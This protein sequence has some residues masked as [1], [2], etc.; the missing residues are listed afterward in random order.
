[1][2]LQCPTKVKENRGILS[3]PEK[4]SEKRKKKK[5]KTLTRMSKNANTTFGK[6]LNLPE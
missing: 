4:E 5:I 1:L 3:V 2:Y 6:Q